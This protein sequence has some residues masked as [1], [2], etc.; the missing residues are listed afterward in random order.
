MN[1]K[2]LQQGDY[3]ITYAV[4]KNEE[5]IITEVMQRET[6]AKKGMIYLKDDVWLDA[7]A[8]IGCFSLWASSK[9]KHI[10]AFEPSEESYEL[11]CK[12]LKQNNITNVTPIRAAIR[13]DDEKTTDFYI[14]KS[15]MGYRMKKT[16]GREKVT[17]PSVNI[18]DIL[19]KYNINAMKIDIEAAEYEV[20]K[21]IKKEN[22]LPIRK[23]W[24]EWHFL[25]LKDI[26]RSKYVEMITIFK[27]MFDIQ[28]YRKDTKQYWMDTFNFMKS[29]ELPDGK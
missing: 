27:S 24:C 7:G 13:H 15:S 29:K 23:F 25:M 12:N 17:V 10:Y 21:A 16:R 22:W 20:L 2:T 8:H 11:L 19:E 3:N 5:Y 28:N 18:N 26:D 4:D 9:V 14:G 1:T 6:Y